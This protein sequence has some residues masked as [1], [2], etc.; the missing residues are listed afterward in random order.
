M[1]SEKWDRRFLELAAF[2]AQWSKDPSTKTGAAIVRPDKTVASI[3]YNGFAKGASDDPAI[4]ADRKVKY[5]LIIHCE[6]NALIHSREPVEGYALYTWPFACCIR[7]AVAMLQAGIRDF[8]APNP[9]EDALTRWGDS[10]TMTRKHILDC[11]GKV[12]EIGKPEDSGR[13]AAT[14]MGWILRT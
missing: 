3:G 12:T 9:T 5:D 1:F 14:C 6:M 8:V 2:V 13:R 11:G 7:C 4:Y 10:F